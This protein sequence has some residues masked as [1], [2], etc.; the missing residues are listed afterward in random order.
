MRGAHIAVPGPAD[1]IQV[2]NRPALSDAGA[3]QDPLLVDANV[4]IDQEF[5]I[6]YGFWLEMSDPMQV[7]H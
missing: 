3:L 4:Q 6:Q 1:V 5:V 2:Q 7:K